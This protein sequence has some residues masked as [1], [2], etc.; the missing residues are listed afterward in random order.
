MI[1]M[2]YAFAF[3]S[4]MLS[5]AIFG[6]FYAWICSTMWG[7]DAAD[8]VV[9][10]KAMQA[11]NDSVRNMVFA[12]AFFGTPFALAIA[13]ALA[14]AAGR[15]KAASAFGA[16]A[17]VYVCGGLLLTIAVNVPMNEALAT[18]DATTD[19]ARAQS[20]WQAY[21]KPWQAWNT[22]RAIAS[23]IALALTGFAIFSMRKQ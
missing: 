16:A 15:R 20:I 6:F 19:S 8:P 9:A 5:G 14:F 18:I 11:M 22:V 3:L 4:L 1:G 7:L 21:S 23:G 17:L 13:A 12:P 10:I 2:L